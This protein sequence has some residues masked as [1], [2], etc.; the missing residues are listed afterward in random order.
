MIFF[1]ELQFK[2]SSIHQISESFTSVPLNCNL[3]AADGKRGLLYVGHKNKITVLKLGNETNIEWKIDLVLPD[4]V[5]KL[6]LSCDFSY[7]AVTLSAPVV[8]IYSAASL[9]RN[10]SISN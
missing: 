10:V 9:S 6:S 3:V 5:S 4:I 7:L 1:K 8:L 2:Q